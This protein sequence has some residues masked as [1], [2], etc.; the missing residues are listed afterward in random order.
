LSH[1]TSNWI[2]K[3]KNLLAGHWWLTPMILATQEAVIRM[4]RV[5]KPAWANS[6]QDP[7]S[8]NP[9]QKR[10]GGGPFVVDTKRVF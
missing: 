10:V 6:L 5:L 9:S 8:K 7:I 1:S 2:I 4:I 3:K